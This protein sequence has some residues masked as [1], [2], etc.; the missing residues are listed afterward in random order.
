MASL[1]ERDGK[2]Y[3]RWTEGGRRK[4]RSL[5][6]TS[7]ARARVK[8]REIE[9][10]LDAGRPVGYRRDIEVEQFTGQFLEYM[11]AHK[12]AH[13]V[14]TI[15]HEWRHFVEWAKPFRLG[16][17]TPDAVERYKTALLAEGYAKSTVRSTLLCLSSVFKT[18]IDRMHVLEGVN[19]CKGIELPKP[20]EQIP[21][22]LELDE[23][24][25]LLVAAENHSV[26]M[27][28]VMALG[29][30]AGLR[31]NEIVH[32]RGTWI[33]YKGRGRVLVQSEGRF[34]TKSGRARKIP[35][36][37]RLRAILERC[38]P[39]DR[40]RFIVYPD[41]LE[42][43]G[44]KTVYRV[45]F[46]EAFSTV[47]KMAELDNVTP[48]TLRHTFASQHAMAGISLYKIG[49]WLGHTS[50]KT[51]MIYAHLSPDDAEIDSF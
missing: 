16:D 18:A 46:T 3:A 32:C 17:V 43:S 23:I 36:S 22:Y 19:P 42:K 8:L 15:E 33:D 5:N 40:E 35:L 31:K 49:T 21:R 13:T 25:R 48:H 11:R 1:Y 26:D 20:D 39:A 47:C 44:A 29:V 28:L 50:P 27:L 38:A 34:Q 6:T 4:R 10:A 7:V 30:F 24:D 51:T 37:T 2:W 14:K 12:R 45:D 41:K 9:E